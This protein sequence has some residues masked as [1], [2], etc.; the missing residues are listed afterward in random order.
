LGVYLLG[1]EVIAPDDV[2][3]VG[4]AR[5]P[6]NEQRTLTIHWDGAQWSIVPSANYT[7]HTHH[8]LNGITAVSS[9][10][11]WAAGSSGNVITHDFALTYGWDGTQWSTAFVFEGDPYETNLRSLS[12]AAPDDVWA[13]GFS[14]HFPSEDLLIA[15]WNGSQWGQVPGP[16]VGPFDNALYGVS[17]VGQGDAWAVGFQGTA[18]D[19]VRA[20]TLRWGGS[21]WSVVPNAFTE[22]PSNSWLRGVDGASLSDVWAVGYRIEDT[23]PNMV[24]SLTMRWDGS[25]WAHVPSPNA[26]AYNYLNAVAVTGH[27]PGSGAGAW[28]V[29][30]YSPQFGLQRTLVMRFDAPPCGNITPTRAPT[31]LPTGTPIPHTSTPT[32]PAATPTSMPTFTPTRVPTS[33]LPTSTQPLQTGTPVQPTPTFVAPTST[34]PVSPSATPVSP[35][36][37]APIICTIQFSDVL[38][39]NPFYIFVRCLACRGIV[40]GYP[41]GT[42]RPGD[43]VTR[44]QLSKIVSNAAGFSE[45]HGGQTFEDVPPDNT[46]FAFIE[47]LASRGVVSGY[48]CGGP[49]EPCLP[50]N[51]PYFRPGNSVTRGQTAKIVAVAAGLPDPPAG[52]HTF[53]DVAPT[54]TFYRWV[55]RMALDAVISGYACGGEGEPCVPPNDR[56]YFRPGN[57]VTRG[58]AA[59]I[60]ANT[61]FPGCAP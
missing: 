49:G 13:V 6:N 28:A 23:E 41:D 53:Q 3:A 22:D 56:P 31:L 19:E 2:W 37:T 33:V 1:V 39:D 10:Q 7:P 14:T 5:F 57:S 12:V 18:P 21:Q 27:E 61:F 58:Q 11:I 48:E 35:S 50:G 52:S 47:R 9:N 59:K 42:F 43:T 26:G 44:G 30:S 20:L 40:G 4:A 15:R 36:P 17:A 45:P 46:F 34:N 55:E 54:H 16:D 8:T 25:E 29:G 24:Q 60:S 32:Q 51:R 38:P